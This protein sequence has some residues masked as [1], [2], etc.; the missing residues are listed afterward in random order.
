MK[1]KSLTYN[2][3]KELSRPKVHGQID[4]FLDQLE[5]IENAGLILRSAEAMAVDKIIFYKP[6]FD[7]SEHKL[8]KISRST[9]DPLNIQKLDQGDNV[10]LLFQNYEQVCAL[11]YTNQSKSIYHYDP[12]YPLLLVIGSEQKGISD[13]M[14]QQIEHAIHIPM[15]GQQSSMNVAC[16]TTAAL[17]EITKHR[18]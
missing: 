12:A 2:E 8:R 5:N 7:W 1:H 6:A 15:L 13:L 17:V 18:I 4:L 10:H 14:L 16:A 11:E 9:I 3:W